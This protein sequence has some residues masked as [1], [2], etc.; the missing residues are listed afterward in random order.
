MAKKAGRVVLTKQE[1]DTIAA[2]EGIGFQPLHR[3]RSRVL[4]MTTVEAPGGEWLFVATE[5]GVYRSRN[6]KRWYLVGA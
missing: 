6:G 1:K 4:A 5:R 2:L 3:F